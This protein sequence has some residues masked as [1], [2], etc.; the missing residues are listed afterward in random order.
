MMNVVEA[1]QGAVLE[2][3][4]ATLRELAAESRRVAAVCSSRRKA[5]VESR[6]RVEEWKRMVTADLM[7]GAVGA[8]R[9]IGAIGALGA[10]GA[11]G[12]IGAVR[13]VGAVGAVRAVGG[14]NSTMEM[15]RESDWRTER[16][17]CRQ[18]LIKCSSKSA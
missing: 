17:C 14:K 7:A 15:N 16:S 1:Y 11:L 6:I 12:A 13:A 5:A 3:V 18:R 2:T 10:L 4:L 9:A 8:V